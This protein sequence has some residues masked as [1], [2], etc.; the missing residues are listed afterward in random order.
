MRYLLISLKASWPLVD[1]ALAEAEREWRAP[2]HHG[3]GW[4]GLGYNLGW[5]CRLIYSPWCYGGGESPMLLGVVHWTTLGEE[6][7]ELLLVKVNDQ[8]L[9]SH[10]FSTLSV[11]LR[12]RLRIAEED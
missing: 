5:D 9:D 1:L 6:F 12:H 7:L 3:H 11:A 10:G 8:V 2:L 4:H